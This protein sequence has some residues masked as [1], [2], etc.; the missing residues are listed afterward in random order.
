[1]V[2]LVKMP[3]N[4]HLFG[5][6]L[7]GVGKTLKKGFKRLQITKPIPVKAYGRMPSASSQM[8][9]WH[10]DDFN[11]YTKK[12]WSGN[13]NKR[14]N[15]PLSYRKDFQ[16]RLLNTTIPNL[17]VTP[18]ALYAMDDMG[19]FDN[20]ILR[21]PP[22][23]LRSNCGEK[24]RKLAYFYMENPHIKAWGLPWK[25]LLRSR[26][27]KDPHYARYLH[28]LRKEA[29]EQRL[30][31]R[32]ARYSPYYLPTEASGLRPAMQDFIEGSPEM[33]LRPWWNES[34]ELQK[35]FRRRLQEA[36]PFERAHPDH[37]EPD[38]Y[39]LGEGMGGGGKSGTALR[40]RSKTHKYRQ[41]RP[42]G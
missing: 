26:D 2:R 15:T 29:A 36:K 12:T 35:A 7:Q 40:R 9:L 28:E 23:E 4:L 18:S 42:Y 25:V 19:G 5:K 13:W 41:L 32:H 37:R 20:Y 14:F 11:Y 31:K 10:N 16:S 24:M 22:E 38:G 39:R 33:Q 17:R 1:M 30:A 3:K 34:T 27:Q 21:T 8:A 6:Y